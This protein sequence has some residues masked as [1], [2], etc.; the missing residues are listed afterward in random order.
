MKDTPKMQE[1]SEKKSISSYH[2][3]QAEAVDFHYTGLKQKFLNL[4]L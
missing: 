4:I 2:L 3:H 1:K